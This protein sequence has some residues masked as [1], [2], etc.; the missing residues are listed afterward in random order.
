MTGIFKPKLKICTLNI[1]FSQKTLRTRLQEELNGC[2]KT[3]EEG[4]SVV[5]GPGSGR[6]ITMGIRKHVGSG[7]TYSIPA[8]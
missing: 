3:R 2:A 1:A 4:P 5:A 8:E 7:D 6:Y